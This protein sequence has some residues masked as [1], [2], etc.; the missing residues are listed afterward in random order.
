[1]EALPV[2]PLPLLTTH[3]ATAQCMGKEG[4]QVAVDTLGKHQRRLVVIVTTHTQALGSKATH[5]PEATGATMGAKAKQMGTKVAIAAA[6]GVK[7]RG[8]KAM[9]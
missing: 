9:T 1:M 2:R 4:S 3:T 6:M 5:T 7:A 8:V